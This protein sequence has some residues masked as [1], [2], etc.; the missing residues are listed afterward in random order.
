MEDQQPPKK[1]RMQRLNSRRARRNLAFGMAAGTLGGL[2]A[3]GSDQTAEPANQLAMSDTDAEVSFVTPKTWDIQETKNDKVDFFIDFLR[4]DN[5]DKTKLWLERLGKYGPMIQKKL[6]ERGMPQ[7]LIWL[8]TIESGLDPNAYSAADAAGIWQFIEETGERHGLE[9]SQYVDERRDP[10]AST[11][12][13]LDYLKKLNDRF[14]GSWYLAAAGY[15][16][17]ENRVERIVREQAGGRFGDES[18]YWEISGN[19]PKETRDYVPVMLAMGH[20]G[21]DPAKYGFT[22]IEPQQPL[23][24][25]E[26]KVAGGT[27]LDDVAK[28]V[29][30]EPDV[31]YD[32]NPHLIKKMTPPNREWSVRIPVQGEQENLA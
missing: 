12:A 24:F 17:G 2:A 3:T 16:T 10:I 29:G 27:S 26:L 5:R 9:V 4:L 8:A 30:V 25:D 18:V 1:S 21:K 28:K 22:D 7:D 20:I 6:A 19:L 31:I 11:D 32:L 13:A 15:N 14:E 23:Q